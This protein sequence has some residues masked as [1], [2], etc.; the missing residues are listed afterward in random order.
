MA[1]KPRNRSSN[2][3]ALAKNNILKKT[4]NKQNNIMKLKV[5][6]VLPKAAGG[7]ANTLGW[8]IGAI[9]VAGLGYQFVYK[10]WQ[11]KQNAKKAV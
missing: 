4:H 3:F 5:N 7:S 1:S 10:P 6:S 2:L 8:I 11:E 9:V